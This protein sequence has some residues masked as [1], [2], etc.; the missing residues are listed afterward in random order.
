MITAADIGDAKSGIVLP[1][2]SIV[3]PSAR[4]LAKQRGITIEFSKTSDSDAAE[5]EEQAAA[6]SRSAR[7]IAACIDHTNLA[8]AASADDITAL[9]TE[10]MEHGF[11]AVCVHPVRVA[12]AAAHLKESRIPVC[13]VVGFPDGAHATAVK[14]AEAERCVT[15][16]AREIDMVAHHGRLRDGEVRCYADDIAAVRRA[17]GD[18]VTLKVIIEASLLDEADIVRAGALCAQA[19]ANYVKTSTGVYGQARL[20]DVQLLRRALDS[21][22]KIKA[23]GGIGTAADAIAFLDAGADRLGTSV[24]VVI[25]WELLS[26]K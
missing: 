1:T 20:R 11:A 6:P 3:T 9:C 2:G 8:P 12:L 25:A 18:G 4:E 7:E 14:V 10:A 22:V 5:T 21:A 19:G 16:G 15:D 26:L 17:I 24:S 23:A 13:A